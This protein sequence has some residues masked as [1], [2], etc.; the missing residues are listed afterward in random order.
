MT[1][2]PPHDASPAASTVSSSLT[3]TGLPAPPLATND[4]PVPLPAVPVASS[5]ASSLPGSR[6][7]TSLLPPTSSAPSSGHDTDESAPSPLPRADEMPSS[8]SS[9]LSLT[10]W[11]APNHP[12]HAPFMQVNGPNCDIP[13]ADISRTLTVLRSRP[14]QTGAPTADLPSRRE[15]PATPASMT[16]Q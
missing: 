12:A 4:S 14:R 6:T 10:P 9:S 11:H 5:T 1:Q 15:S 16:D 3:G 2:S 7:P 13:C 8:T